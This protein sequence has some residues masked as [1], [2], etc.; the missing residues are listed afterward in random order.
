MSTR[1]T[2]TA[3]IAALLALSCVASGSSRMLASIQAPAQSALVAASFLVQ[4]VV[5]SQEGESWQLLGLAD[6][7]QTPDTL[8]QG[9]GTLPGTC[10]W[11][12]G[13]L[14]NG[15]WTLRI[16]IVGSTGLRVTTRNVV[17]GRAQIPGFPKGAAVQETGFTVQPLAEPGAPGLAWVEG[18]A[19][20]GIRGVP[21]LLHL[22]DASG[23][24][25][26]GF[27]RDLSR[28]GVES[29]RYSS[30]VWL[31]TGAEPSLALLGVTQLVR[32]STNGTL[33]ASH[34]FDGVAASELIHFHTLAGEPRLLFASIGGTH[35]QLHLLDEDLVSLWVSDFPAQIPGSN[36]P[37]ALADLDG[38][39][40]P[41]GWL[42]LY[43]QSSDLGQ[44]WRINLADG[45]ASLFGNV[46]GLM[47]A[48]LL[49]GEMTGDL[50]TDLVMCGSQDAVSAWDANGLLW[51]RH[52]LG[53][54]FSRGSLVDLDGDGR[55]EFCFTDHADGSQTHLR[56]LNGQG[57][58]CGPLDG[59]T[60]GLD[61][62]L[63]FEPLAADMD[64]DG[65]QD[66]ILA[67]SLKDPTVLHGQV[68]VLDGQ[69]ELLDH[70][71]L[72][73]KPT[74]ALRLQDLDGD[75]TSELLL[76]DTF[77]RLN[78]WNT[79]SRDSRPGLP[80][81]EIGR[82]GRTLKVIT[83]SPQGS[84]WLDGRLLLQDSL[85]VDE[86]MV[87]SGHTLTLLSGQ[88]IVR[89]CLSLSEGIRVNAG[90]LLHF[91]SGSQVSQPG[92]PLEV[93]GT[94]S[95]HGEVV[96]NLGAQPLQPSSLASIL[97]NSQL[98][99][100]SGARLELVDCTL[101]GLTNRLVLGPGQELSLNGVWLM[102]GK[103][104]HL[105][106]ASLVM[107]HSV[108]HADS[109]A[110]SLKAG[111]QAQIH[112][113]TFSSASTLA[114]Q[115]ADS[116]VQ[117]T[118]SY[119]L[120]NLQGIEVSGQSTLL[121]DSCHFQGNGISLTVMGDADAVSVL[122]S[123]FV[124]SGATAVRN[125]GSGQLLASW[126]YWNE[127]QPT[128]GDVQAL[129]QSDQAW[130]PPETTAPVFEV[131]PGPM[132]NGDEPLLSWDPV[133]Y[134][135]NGIP[136]VVSYRVYR[137]T[138][139]YDLVRPENLVATVSTPSWQSQNAPPRCFYAVTVWLGKTMSE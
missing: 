131:R 72:A 138:E 93:A 8:A 109:L 22:D 67:T 117:L 66:L 4:A 6:G 29:C 49:S 47:P 106:G 103:G 71:V 136:V 12:V 116:D 126:C 44:L 15:P 33:L 27:P 127:L 128:T 24:P 139:P 124:E 32:Y 107:D 21:Q 19:L 75:G 108:L 17:V 16:E 45:G 18:I 82:G 135:L 35:S 31:S 55:Q 9:V 87:L 95:L 40:N 77:N 53:R 38:D 3:S 115:V 86:G 99:T 122:H 105:E 125:L 137:S 39:L 69:G 58:P 10:S 78:A 1:H 14:E 76:T 51:L 83:G 120:N 23:L 70:W 5:P 36:L 37:L 64:G 118:S 80:F 123:D 111:S 26:P 42:G 62:R 96:N 92:M 2:I 25:L 61:Q 98:V 112:N 28:D 50:A 104:I 56:L 101:A 88:M 84:A 102:A 65:D 113:S 7:S 110:L 63:G 46:P 34:S 79:P 73:G 90:A 133:E 119:L 85:V 81:G 68:R 132:I 54:S 129:P 60:L 121:A 59:Q 48:Q 11:Q 89:G 57:E 30:P 20:D 43:E 100:E 97:N 74:S 13:P 52:S 94:L 41:E 91:D 130:F 114:L 134:T